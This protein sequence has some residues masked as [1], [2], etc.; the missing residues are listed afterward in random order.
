M[1]LLWKPLV[2]VSILAISQSW[3]RLPAARLH[4]NH[5][6]MRTRDIS[7]TF[8]SPM[9]YHTGEVLPPLN[10]TYYFDQLIDHSN[11][12]LGTFKQRYW[13]TWE[14]YKPGEPIK[15]IGCHRIDIL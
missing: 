11:A 5:L 14:W 9:N 12:S 13:H 6:G 15:I 8:P 7:A 10:T 3:G 2:L 4:K 1:V